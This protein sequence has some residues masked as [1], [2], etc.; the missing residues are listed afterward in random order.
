MFLKKYSSKP[1]VS[2]LLCIVFFSSI[3]TPPAKSK[4]ILIEATAIK[5]TTEGVFATAAIL[6]TIAICAKQYM[7]QE[8]TPF[9]YA[10]IPTETSLANIPPERN[11]HKES[12]LQKINTTAIDYIKLWNTVQSRYQQYVHSIDKNITIRKSHIHSQTI[13]DNL[14]KTNGMRNSKLAQK[15][16]N[17]FFEA[18]ARDHHPENQAHIQKIFRGIIDL[19]IDC[20]SEDI[21][22]RI[23]ARI[24]LSHASG[25]DP[26]VFGHTIKKTALNLQ[27]RYF[28]RNND[29]IDLSYDERLPE[30]IKSILMNPPYSNHSKEL[31][32][33]LH[34]RVQENNLDP[35]NAFGAMRLRDEEGGMSTWTKLWHRNK[36][37]E[38]AK[39]KRPFFLF[40]HGDK[41][42]QIFDNPNNHRLFA[43]ASLAQRGDFHLASKLATT[44]LEH[45]A[46][47]HCQ[48]E[49]CNEYGILKQ[50]QHFS[51]WQQLS[52]KEKHNIAHHEH[53]Q[54]DMN[55]KLQ[56]ESLIFANDATIATSSSN[57][58]IGDAMPTISPLPP[59]DE[60]DPDD[61]QEYYSKDNFKQYKKLKDS[62]REQEITSVIKTTKHGLKR[63]IERDFTGEEIRAILEA[64][65][66]TASQTD[67]SR[68]FIKQISHNRYD[69]IVKNLADEAITG[70]KYLDDRAIKNLI[71]NYT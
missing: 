8:D 16:I 61:D 62:L 40:R 29:L 26:H 5:I 11:A 25:C 51:T 71:K 15:A 9:F 49:L 18:S 2:K 64:P 33:Q 70:M 13:V 48:N 65:D 69:Y 20:N 37:Y 27:E 59:M 14:K 66:R 1:F 36:N 17:N 10:P 30:T 21:A 7:N 35:E 4:P 45:Q 53:L 50:H 67:G 63:L 44:K 24:W 68:I 46:I 22:R 47:K 6:S 34:E 43:I 38:K 32:Q 55:E 56:K 41:R 3:I 52:P 58:Q 19:F 39:T 31:L 12:T 54:D 60:E 28:D 42:K 57:A 23:E